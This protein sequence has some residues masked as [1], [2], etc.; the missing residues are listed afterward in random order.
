[1]KKCTN[2]LTEKPLDEF[3]FKNKETGTRKS[4]CKDCRTEERRQRYVDN[5]DHE[6]MLS[7]TYHEQHREK[8]NRKARQHYQENREQYIARDHR[9]RIGDME[10][11]DGSATR[12]FYVYVIDNYS[13]CVTCGVE[14][15]GVYPEHTALTMGH[16]IPLNR[17][18]MTSSSNILPQCNL[19]NLQQGRKTLE[20]WGID[21]VVIESIEEELENNYKLF[22]PLEIDL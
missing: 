19:C 8:M 22:P 3:H 16:M 4:K 9:R 6:N 17:G 7:R 5:K 18:G 15:E 20:E 21:E 14:F 2:C 11:R 13:K 10:A 1:M 12:A